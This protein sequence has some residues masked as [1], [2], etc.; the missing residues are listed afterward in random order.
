MRQRQRWYC[1]LYAVQVSMLYE[2]LLYM[3]VGAMCRVEHRNDDV[4]ERMWFT[5]CGKGWDQLSSPISNCRCGH[6]P[7][8]A[9]SFSKYLQHIILVQYR[10]LTAVTAVT[11][12]EHNA[13]KLEVLACFVQFWQCTWWK[14]VSGRHQPSSALEKYVNLAAD[15]IDHKAQDAYLRTVQVL[16][17]QRTTVYAGRPA[18]RQPI[19]RKLGRQEEK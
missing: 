3:L 19:M 2:V 7:G 18:T 14:Y 17:S 10:I 5:V 4:C 13:P 15:E 9:E 1:S 16:R 6:I 8:N 12:E 11:A